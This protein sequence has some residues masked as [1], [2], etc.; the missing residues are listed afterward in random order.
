MKYVLF[1]YFLIAST[2]VVLAQTTFDKEN[3][4]G[5]LFF[6]ISTEVRPIALFN[7]N[8]EFNE[9][10]TNFVDFEDQ[11]TGLA[12]SYAFDWFL[13]KSFS[14]GFSHSLRY[15]HTFSGQIDP[16]QLGVVIA[17]EVNDLL[18]DFH[19]Y[20]Q[21]HIKVSKTSEVFLQFG[22]STLNVGSNFNALQRFINPATNMVIAGLQSSNNTNYGAWNWG[23]G[24]KKKRY[25]LLA[26][27]FT[28][29]TQEYFNG[30][31]SLPYLRF[32]YN[33]GKL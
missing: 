32:S 30:I 24:W 13:T 25:A 4:K 33:L 16:D 3:R 8:V 15:D 2:T 12:F 14:I 1:I 23:V 17:E 29:G 27:V 28:S 10:L 18:M 9:S 31:L 21:Y 19:F 5:K 22:R 11:T 6:N 20:L 7:D 26:G